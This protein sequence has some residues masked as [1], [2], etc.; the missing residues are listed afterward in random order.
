MKKVLLIAKPWRGGLAR[1]IFLALEQL[2]PGRVEWV[3]TRPVSFADQLLYRLN[4]QRWEQLLVEK[5][6][7]ADRDMALF[8][9]HLP[10]FSSLTFHPGNVLWL[11]DGPDPSSGDFAPYAKVFLS[12]SGYLPNVARVLPNERLGGELGFAYSPAI[13]HWR[14]TRSERK[15]LCFIGNKDPKRDPYIEA[16]LNSDIA[17]SFVGNYFLRHRLFWR[18]PGSFSSSVSNEKM[19]LTYADHQLS[20][21]LHAQV[22]RQGTNMRTFECAGYG[23][24][25]LVEYRPGLEKY[26]EADREIL[27]FSGPEEMLDNAK[28]LLSDPEYRKKLAANAMSRAAEEHTYV[29]RMQTILEHFS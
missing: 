23:I 4:K 3:P 18:L 17:C 12:D 25:Q 1:Y 14:K 8:L 15:Q 5:I 22:V 29:H 2:F 19:G 6:R 13:H 26:F 24:P 16:L 27:T 21:N 10:P 20:L 28:K 11:T 9:N 7:T